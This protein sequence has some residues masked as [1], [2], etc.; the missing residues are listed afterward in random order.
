VFS[1][2]LVP[3]A[4]GPDGAD[5]I[6]FLFAGGPDA[7]PLPLRKV[8]SSGETA[9]VMLAVKTVLTAADR[10][11]I[12]VFDEVDANIGGR[13]AVVV[14][15]E[16]RTVARHHQVLCITHLPQIAAAGDRHYWVT[17]E[18]VD[19][20]SVTRVHHLGPEERLAEITRMLGAPEN[21]GA[22]LAH[23]KELL[24]NAAR[25]A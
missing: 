8:A 21:S 7:E 18:I 16:L 13:A 19:S 15:E 20:R 3:K 9:R 6:E 5:A 11:P 24:E 1:V 17:K 4:P 23:A 12:L 25:T 22:A 14:G 10:V 2:A